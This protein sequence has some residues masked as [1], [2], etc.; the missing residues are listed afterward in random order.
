MH[1]TYWNTDVRRDIAAGLAFV[2]EQAPGF[3][4]R[5]QKLPSEYVRIAL[6]QFLRAIGLNAPESERS[7]FLGCTRVRPMRH[8]CRIDRRLD[9]QMSEFVGLDICGPVSTHR[10]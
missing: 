5:K 8:D 4:R 9:P 2:D 6:A 7:R 10:G 3:E 1:Q